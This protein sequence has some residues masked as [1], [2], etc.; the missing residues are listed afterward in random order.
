MIEI[1][2]FVLL[3]CEMKNMKA[4]NL[5][6]VMTTERKRLQ[7]TVPPDAM[8][9]DRIDIVYAQE[10]SVPETEAL[11]YRF[12][13]LE[14][15]R[16]LLRRR[17]QA[18]LYIWLFLEIAIVI[19]LVLVI[20]LNTDATLVVSSACGM[21][22]PLSGTLLNEVYLNIFYG[23]SGSASTCKD[24][25][26]SWC[27]PW[28]ADGWFLFEKLS[29][30]LPSGTGGTLA[31]RYLFSAQV[32]IGLSLGFTAVGAILH[33]CVLTKRFTEEYALFLASSYILLIAFALS[34]ASLSNVVT[35]SPFS[36]T[37]WTQYLRSG[38]TLT[39]LIDNTPPT[40]AAALAAP[41]QSCTATI[42]FQGGALLSAS[43]AVLFV[44]TVWSLFSGCLAGPIVFTK[45][46]GMKSTS[47]S[48]AARPADADGTGDGSSAISI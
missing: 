35:A 26:D 27:I 29:G 5:E 45:P 19:F 43:V 30:Y 6:F 31:S 42:T 9:G 40:A 38:A 13:L 3:L 15:Q 21:A 34:I 4:S 10:R 16:T 18:T 22:D 23:L 8:P 14:Q 12:N 24:S 48:T 17:F 33:G 25:A 32:L 39:D 7:I 20:A 1:Y 2:S 41:N 46:S 47:R 37:N 44:L 36:S 28:T 11:A